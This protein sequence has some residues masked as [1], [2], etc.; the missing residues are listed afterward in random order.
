MTKNAVYIQSGGPTTVI[1]AS[2]YGVISAC[3]QNKDKIGKLYSALHGTVGLLSGK[4]IDVYAE[5]PAELKLLTQTPSSAFG[6]CRYRMQDA[7][8]DDTDYRRIVENFARHDVGYL[9]YNGGN[10]T[11]RACH[12]LQK[13]ME[14]QGYD[15]KVVAIPKTVDNDIAGIDHAPGF[16]SAARHAAISIS[17]LAHD[18]RVYDTGLITV[19]EVM[20]RNTG[21]LAASTLLC[22]KAGNGPDLIYTPELMFRPE[23]FIADVRQVYERKGK[24]MAVVAEGVKD[25]HGKYLFEYNLHSPDQPSLNMG[26][27]TPYLTHILLQ[28]FPCKVRGIDLGLM[29]RC[30]MHTASKLDVEEAARLGEMAVREALDGVTGKLVTLKRI[31]SRP[32]AVRE[33]ILD[34]AQAASTDG[35]MP[36]SYITK[37]Q[38]FI[39]DSFLEYIEPLVGELPSYARLQLKVI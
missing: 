14:A 17:E 31:S 21:W 4:L 19:I 11:L 9:F 28:N 32:Y 25:T 8:V 20:G 18:I 16:P 13:Y 5:D 34:I 38:N 36:T 12:K 29:Q 27:I 22:A 37:E 1:N 6:S 7:D 3:M 15:C 30:G 35:T 24:C 39:E 10:G 26:G 23:K 2:A 33:S